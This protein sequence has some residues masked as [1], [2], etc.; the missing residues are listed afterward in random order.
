VLLCDV[1]GVVHDGVRAF[2]GPCAALVRWRADRGPV[3]LI[4]NSPRPRA[5]V[6][7]Q[8]DQLGAPR[9]A[10]SA[11]VT[12]GDVTRDLLAC[13]APGPAWW[14]GPERDGALFEGSG[15]RFSGPEEADFIACTGLEDDETQTPG[16]Y[17]D[18]LAIAAARGLEMICAN[19][20][21][22]VQ[23][24]D[25]LIWCAGALAELYETLGG[26]VLMAGKPF[27][28][29]YRR[30]FAESEA[31]LGHGL[32]PPRVLVIGDGVATDIAGAN[33]QGLDVLFVAGGIHAAD[34]AQASRVDLP[35]RAAAFLK[36]HR[37]RADFIID[38][39][40]WSGASRHGPR[41]R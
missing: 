25:R 19:P 14:I 34:F 24:G 28:P 6:A 27:T 30:A 8:L 11:L 29:I 26:A 21:R 40:R 33:R 36:E 10:W 5:D 20:D 39:L 15:M 7:V 12:S 37:A 1:W 31:I 9:E 18:A 16:D 13:R 35:L 3:I 32:E 23:R 38:E 17:G 41:N 4:S 22:V 2:P